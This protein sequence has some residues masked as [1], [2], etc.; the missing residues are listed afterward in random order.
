MEY[1]LLVE[2]WIRVSYGNGN[3]EQLGILDIVRR[4]HGIREICENSPMEEFGIFRLVQLILLDAYR[5]QTIDDI[6]SILDKGSF[7]T[8]IVESYIA[9]CKEEGVTFDI[10]NSERP[11][12][13]ANNW[14]KDNIVSV[15]KLNPF[16]PSGTN[17]V[18]FVHCF[19]SEARMSLADTAKAL[20]A[21]YLFATPG[22]RGYVTGPCGD[23][24]V[25]CVPHG[26]NLF[27]TLVY[28]LVPLGSF[29]LYG[30]P[31]VIWRDDGAVE[32]GKTEPQTSLFRGM[33]FPARKI[34]IEQ[35]EEGRYVRT[36]NYAPGEKLDAGHGFY[37]PNV[38]YFHSEKGIFPVK[39][40]PNK[41]M[42]RNLTTILDRWNSNAC[43]MVVSNCRELTDSDI[44]L[45][46][47]EICND[48][49]TFILCHRNEFKIPIAFVDDE[50]KY[51]AVKA[52]ADRVEAEAYKLGKDISA[53]QI[54]RMKGSTVVESRKRQSYK[55]QTL[56]A[57]FLDGRRVFYDF[58]ASAGKCSPE[59][60]DELLN[61]AYIALWGKRR[62]RFKEYLE[63]LICNSYDR[64]VYEKALIKLRK[65]KEKFL[66]KQQ[67]EES[68]EECE[69]SEDEKTE[70]GGLNND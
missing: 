51:N 13:Q 43:P 66:Q 47:Y 9:R 21:A 25:Y 41:E 33:M 32:S 18:H 46:I 11:F 50:V 22:G 35:V 19:E 14:D 59:D 55:Q 67:K 57:F 26:D 39:S 31:S 34:R 48:K 10:L 1:N 3:T 30:S 37:D 2:P 28:N 60:I 23:R 53:S 38:G 16:M 15:S 45:V 58:L 36:I 70:K 62:D 44:R 61:Q 17:H 24:N 54:G 5:P 40:N 4:A 49:A 69:E 29:E 7:D 68:S 65:E 42:W 52:V 20:C 12:L 6:K 8:S 63:M 64:V 27:E 56:K